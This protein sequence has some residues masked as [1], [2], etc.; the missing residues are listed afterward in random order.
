MT[1]TR[2]P[3]LAGIFYPNDPAVLREDVQRL[4][5]GVDA[6][7]QDPK[8]LIVPH[9]GY[10]YSGKVAA[11]AYACLSL[12]NDIR[13]RVVLL[14]PSHRVYLRGIAVSSA[15]AF[16]TPLGEVPI[17][18]ETILALG[19]FRQVSILDQAHRWEHS[20]EVQLP[21]LQVRLRNFSLVPLVVGDIRPI[22][23]AQV[24]ESLWGDT[25]TLF[26]V[27]SDLSHYHDYKTAQAIDAT[28]SKAIENLLFEEIHA[29]HACGCM[30]LNGLLCFARQRGLRVTTLELKNSGDTAGGRNRVVGYGAYAV[31]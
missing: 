20:L 30:P 3:A 15:Q 7:V 17:D 29:E 11:A 14:G 16:A 5:E 18:E 9:A 21:F 13:Q 10:V 24:I 23:L 8:A 25:N 28:T 26:I 19:D 22:E 12:R 4:L 6:R 2:L 31:H 27:S 1:A